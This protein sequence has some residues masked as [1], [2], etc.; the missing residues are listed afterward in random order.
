MARLLIRRENEKRN[1]TQSKTK[2]DI[3]RIRPI[4]LI[5][6]DLLRVNQFV[7]FLVWIPAYVRCC[8]GKPEMHGCSDSFP[9]SPGGE[10]GC[11]FNNT[12]RVV[13]PS[14]RRY[15]DVVAGSLHMDVDCEDR[16]GAS[17]RW[18]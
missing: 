8:P 7:F 3:R 12:V 5:D 1:R 18:Q 6:F 2:E 14:E 13:E 11:L 4:S 17:L 16:M 9:R 10:G 15:M